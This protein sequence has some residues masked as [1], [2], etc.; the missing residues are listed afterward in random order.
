MQITKT[1][2]TITGYTIK[3]SAKQH[4]CVV[5]KTGKFP[6]CTVTTKTEGGRNLPFGKVFHGEDCLIQA[7]DSYK[8]ATV[9]K[10]L[11]TVISNL[12]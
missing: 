5:V 10:A 3:I 4:L 11:R 8:R 1:S 9:K 6:Y 12:I 2:P 7:L